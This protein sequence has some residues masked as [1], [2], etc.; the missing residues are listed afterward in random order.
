MLKR[1]LNTLKYG[2]SKAKAIVLCIIASGL[3]GVV[4]AVLAIAYKELLLFFG[5]L[6]CVFIIAASLQTLGIYEYKD[7]LYLNIPEAPISAGKNVEHTDDGKKVHRST[8]RGS[9]KTETDDTADNKRKNNKEKKNTKKQNK[10]NQNH[11][12]SN[13]VLN[14]DKE[15]D[16]EELI[17][18]NNEAYE[19]LRTDDFAEKSAP[20]LESEL[21]KD[22]DYLRQKNEEKTDKQIEIKQATEEE[23]ASYNRKKIKKTLHKYKVKRD[24]RLVLVDRSD[25]FHIKQTPAYIWVSNSDFNILL[26]EQEPRHII[27]PLYNI[28]EI[29]YL[30]KQEVNADTDYPALHKK[31]LI[32]D[33]FAPY[34][35]DYTQS[36]VVSDMVS[37]K[38][39]YG[40]EPGIYFT[41]NS[42]KQLFDLLAVDFRVDDKVTTSTKVNRYFKDTY[43]SS[44]LLRDNVI[45]AVGYADKISR[46]LDDMAKSTLS[47]NEFKE[48]LNLMMKN[49]LITQE[50]AMHY[51]EVRDKQ[52]RGN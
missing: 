1:F 43:K 42:A 24:H 44:I 26:I 35:P 3:A 19:D 40:I 13:D 20:T 29:T 17:Q 12:Y 39:L 2:T 4:F 22:I 32:S 9:G 23:L 16:S 33:L 36:T 7:E 46:I 45:D 51:M 18:N 6:I 41:N 31:N 15:S 48:T 34:L 49:K 30:K 10:E 14:N 28:T 25:K 47:Y 5:A 52:R 8:E 50:F 38:N 27:L 37:Y 11:S 21:Q